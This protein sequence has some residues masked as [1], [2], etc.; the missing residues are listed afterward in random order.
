MI[1]LPYVPCVRF[2]ENDSDASAMPD[3]L[4]APVVE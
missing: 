1:R 2:L 3:P 4:K